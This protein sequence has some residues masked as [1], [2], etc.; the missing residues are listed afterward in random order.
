MRELFANVC[1]PVATAKTRGAFYRNWRLTAIDGTTFDLPDTKT[2]VEAFGRPPRS[3]R[4]E[5]DVGYPQ[6]RMVGSGRVRHPRRVRRRDRAVA[7]GRTRPGA[8]GVRIAAVGD[9]AVGRS[10]LLRRRPVAHRRGDRSRPAVAGPQ[11]HR[12]ADDRATSRRLLPERDLRP[13]RHPPHPHRATR[14]GG[15]VHHRRPRRGLPAHHHD[16]RPRRRPRPP[17]WPRSTPNAGNSS[18]HWT[19]SRPISADPTWFCAPNIPT[20]REQEL[21]GFLLVHHAIRHLMHQAATDAGDQTPIGSPSPAPCASCVARS[22]T[23]R[24][25]P[26]GRLARAVKPRWLNCSTGYSHPAPASQPPGHQTENRRLAAQT[27]PPPTS[28]PRTRTGS[29]HRTSNQNPA[30]ETD[31]TVLSHRYWG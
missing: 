7:H 23:R 28:H 22:P 8:G 19:K 27:R 9:A 26:P 10:R 29:H 18:P 17:N 25:F 13:E 4:G 11:R 30:P 14:A 5:Q 12:P 15:R 16:P 6:I 2:N 20:A 1:H 21:Y 31:Q 3:G 24:H